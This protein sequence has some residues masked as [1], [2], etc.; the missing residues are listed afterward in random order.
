MKRI[1][2]L[3]IG[4]LL[5][6]WVFGVAMFTVLLS[7]ALFLNKFSSYLVQ[8]IP[9]STIVKLTCL[10]L[11][12]LLV[13]TFAMAMLLAGLLAFGRL[14]GDSEVVAMR[15]AGASITRI[16]APAGVMA[17]LVALIAFIVDE[18]VVP[19]AAST[20]TSMM[21]E[22]AKKL[23]PAHIQTLSIPITTGGKTR[24]VVVARG[25]DPL[26][27]V[28]EGATVVAYKDDGTNSGYLNA[29]ELVFDPEAVSSGNGWRIQG[30]ATWISADGSTS[31][32]FDNGVWPP[33]V[34]MPNE[35]PQDISALQIS[36]MDVL[37][38]AQIRE[39]I[40]AMRKEKEFPRD[41]V[42]NLEFGYWNKIALPL[43]TFVYG[44][45]GAPLG[46]R[47]NRTSAAAGFALAVAIIFAYFTLIN[48]LN[49]Y[50]MGGVIAPAVASFTPI[51][52]GLV[53]AGV[54]IRLRNV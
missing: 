13:K 19:W 25:Y 8:G 46:I 2:R 9:L 22:I 12:G 15:A 26:R 7:A 29:H 28:L 20:G 14:S 43:A 5:G 11:P 40:N 39:R 6:P 41:T 48:V 36:D 3:I 10:V 32:R 31:L 54:I 30:G 53:A 21:A 49:V 38:M 17:I 18:T 35:T 50:S 16:V 4:E 52:I 51:V 27:K 24:G 1:D 42:A 45:L 47:R 37:S 34:P 44:M 23:D 33:G